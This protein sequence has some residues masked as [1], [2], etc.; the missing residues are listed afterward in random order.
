MIRDLC[1]VSKKRQI[2]EPEDVVPSEEVREMQKQMGKIH[3]LSKVV[4]NEK[5]KL[6]RHSNS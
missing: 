2:C 4:N 5:R 6:H 3:K 1:E